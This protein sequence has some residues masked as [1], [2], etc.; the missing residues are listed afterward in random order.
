MSKA[1]KVVHYDNKGLNFDLKKVENMYLNPV[2]GVMQPTGLQSIVNDQN[3][4]HIATMGAKYELFTN[5]KFQDF[6]ET[7]AEKL[8]TEI[9]H[10]TSKNNGA[11]VICG[12]KKPAVS[13]AGFSLDRF[14]TVVDNRQ[15][16]KPLQVRTT[17]H[18]P[19]CAN[20]ESAGTLFQSV[21]HNASLPMMIDWF[22]SIFEK[23]EIED[24]KHIE[25]M[26]RYANIKVD[27][28]LIEKA[29][30]FILEVNQHETLTTTAANKLL[31]FDE[32]V[33]HENVFAG[34]LFHTIASSTHFATHNLNVSQKFDIRNFPIDGKAQKIT[35]RAFDFCEMHA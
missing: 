17:T 31:L 11:T 28:T 19:R 26:N 30:N 16:R 14:I 13:V 8:G 4:A 34:T 15:G 1:S 12:I 33:R 23:I 18:M 2:T 7:I 20:L 21:F 6:C 9:N 24:A 3:G 29:K 32:S 22:F 25:M 27:A 35:K 10:Y 5:A